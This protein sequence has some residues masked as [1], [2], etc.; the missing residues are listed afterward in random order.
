MK[1]TAGRGEQMRGDA[2]ACFDQ[3]AEEYDRCFLHRYIQK[4]QKRVV[5]LMSPAE[6]AFVLD[7]GCGTGEVIRYLG[8]MVKQGLLAGLD[9]SPQMIEVARRKFA[10][11][12]QVELKIGD[13]EALPWPDSFFDQ[14]MSTFTLHHF[15][16]PD[17]ALAE[18]VRVLKPGGRL[19]LADLVFPPSL[20]RPLN[21]ILRLA[22]MIF[23]LIGQK[24]SP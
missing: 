3:W 11:Q 4:V 20:R 23:L 10:T 22:P 6:D 15:P 24:D 17:R 8:R 7:I 19:F 14:G 16:H 2:L 9:I 18:M 1:E 5:Q 12:T 13:V 21:W